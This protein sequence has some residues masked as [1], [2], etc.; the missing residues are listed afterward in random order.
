[1]YFSFYCNG[2][3]IN[4]YLS[5]YLEPAAGKTNACEFEFNLFECQ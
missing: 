5:I 1:M 4:I 2:Y 3:L